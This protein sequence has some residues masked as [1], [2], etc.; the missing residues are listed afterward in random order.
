[1]VSGCGRSKKKDRQRWKETCRLSPQ[2]LPER[3]KQAILQIYCACTN[4]ITQKE[5][6]EDVPS[7]KENL[8]EI[9]EVLEL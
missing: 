6:F 5:W 3:L 9:K 8:K 1:M 7:L 4:E 2:P